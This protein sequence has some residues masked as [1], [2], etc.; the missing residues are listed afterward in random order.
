M[1]ADTG[2]ERLREAIL[3]GALQPNERLVEAELVASLGVPRAAVRTAIDRLSHEGLVEHERN[4]GAKVRKVGDE[5]A[6]EILQARAVLEGLAARTAAERATDDDVADL[7]RI[8]SAMRERLDAG[9]LLGASE[10]NSTLHARILAIADH[11]TV[12]RLVS[13]LN[14]QIVRFQYRTILVPGRAARSFEEHHAIFEAIADGDPDAAE[15][16]MRTHLDHVGEA[17]REHARTAPA[18]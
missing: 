1:S 12:S 3:S 6:V 18:V 10:R 13:S 7:R 2:Y 8:V 4:R 11:R 9:D 15:S 17:L 5:E 16:A 14:S